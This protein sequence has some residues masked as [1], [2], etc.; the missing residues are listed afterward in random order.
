MW[1]TRLGNPHVFP[2]IRQ[3]DLSYGGRSVFEVVHRFHVQIPMGSAGHIDLDIPA[4]TLTDFASVPRVAWP[5]VF[6]LD[7][8]VSVGALVHDALY[9][10]AFP[11]ASA[12]GMLRLVMEYYGAPWWKQWRV[13]YAVRLF[14]W[15]CYPSQ[16]I[17]PEVLTQVEQIK[18]Y[19]SVV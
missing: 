11:R 1:T 15:L 13:Y 18:R 10:A 19:E 9:V 16:P 7:R 5:L 3:H 6:P 8:H 17:Q 14:G 2:E 4:G 12:D